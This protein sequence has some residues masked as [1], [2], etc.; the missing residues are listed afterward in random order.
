MAG[1]GDGDEIVSPV[2]R[3]FYEMEILNILKT[4]KQK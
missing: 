4:N 3:T 2:N 1:V